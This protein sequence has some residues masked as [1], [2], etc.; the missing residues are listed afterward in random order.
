MQRDDF[1]G[2]VVLITGAS[3]N[4]GRSI[5]VSFGAL[6]ASVMLHA[7]KDREAVEEVAYTVRH[8][9]GTAETILGDLADPCVPLRLVEATLARFGRL[10][11]VVANAAI[12][13]HGALQTISYEDWRQVMAIALDS[14][15]LLA[16][17]VAEPLGHS[18]RASFIAIGGLTGHTGAKDRVHVVTAKA[19]LSGLVKALAHE[20]GDAGI[21]VNCIAP[22][23]I[24]TVRAGGAPAHHTS[25][26][27]VVG[28][29]GT[30]EE[31]AGAVVS[32][33]SP[34]MRY[35]TGQ[36]LHVNGGALMV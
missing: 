1:K 20:L 6:G 13:P 21:T 35:V 34:A 5:A 22:G 23:L 7:M 12:R 28:R 30:V 33:A 2:R 8:A 24:E 31:V 36:T 32:L 29:F 16:K 17:A 19:G 25:I 27:N 10:D 26:N 9:G 4:I 3:R 14:V 11:T 18:D 15:F